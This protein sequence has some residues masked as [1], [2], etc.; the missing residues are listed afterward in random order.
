M[1]AVNWTI[2]LQR[3]SNVVKFI[4]LAL[5]TLIT[6]Y[7]FSQ[8]MV[9]NE[10]RPGPVIDD[11]ILN[12]LTPVNLSTYISI[13]TLIP[14]FGGQVYMLRLP[15]KAVKVLYASIFICLFRALTLLLFPLDPPLGII[16]LADPFIE[17]AFYAGSRLNKDLFFSGHTANLVL[18][19]LLLENKKLK[20]ILFSC[21][22]FVAIML[23]IQHVHYS[24]DVIFAPLFAWFSYKS[25]LW[26]TKITFS[27]ESEKHSMEVLA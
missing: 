6:L 13:L 5:L 22:I 1:K 10:T 14:I 15:A 3:K 27:F 25:S 18:V 26:A 7:S 16:S 20:M 4:I 24:V 12:Y 19:G 21:A 8:F 17:R 11:F 23:M 2:F 9:W